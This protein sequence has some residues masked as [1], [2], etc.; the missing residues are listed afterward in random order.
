M[1]NGDHQFCKTQ[2]NG[3][4]NLEDLEEQ[5]SSHKE[6]CLVTLMH[7]NNEIGNLLDIDAVGNLCKSYNAIFHSDC[8]QT[9]G[10][11]P[12][13]LRKNPCAFYFSSRT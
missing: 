5:L 7:A 8:V 2:S 4:V 13:D 3:H 12:L 6:R 11:Y 10:H 9:V 1:R